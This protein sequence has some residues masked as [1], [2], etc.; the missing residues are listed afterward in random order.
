MYVMYGSL[1]VKN[2]R[3]LPTDFFS[4]PLAELGIINISRALVAYFGK[5]FA[6]RIS[7]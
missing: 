2:A 3:E 5:K 7:N 1:I 6:N 4:R